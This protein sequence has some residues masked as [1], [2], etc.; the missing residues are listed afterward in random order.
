[1]LINK[2]SSGFCNANRRV[3]EMYFE[4]Y[5]KRLIAWII[6]IVILTLLSN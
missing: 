3:L 1:M 2:R 5:P 4:F 6:V